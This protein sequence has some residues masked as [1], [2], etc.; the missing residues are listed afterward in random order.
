MKSRHL[1]LRNFIGVLILGL[2]FSGCSK[3]KKTNDNLI[4]TWTVGTTSFNAMVGTKT[5]EQYFTDVMGLTGTEAQVYS[6]VVNQTIQQSFTGTIQFKSDN[7]Y[8]ST[9]GG[10]NDTG[11]W[12]LN[13]GGTQLTINSS[14]SGTQVFDIVQL[15]SSVLKVGVTNQISEDLNSDGTQESITVTADVTFNK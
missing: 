13:S 11:T 4:G 12:S 2:V 7:T 14:S 10:K 8:S 3:D 9:L 6:A 5:L 1:N 15:T